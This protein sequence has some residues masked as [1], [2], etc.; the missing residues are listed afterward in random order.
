M[1]PRYVGLSLLKVLVF[2]HSELI[3]GAK[4]TV[5]EG[6]LGDLRVVPIPLND[7]FPFEPE[8]TSFIPVSF[9]AIVSDDARFHSWEENTGGCEV[10][11]EPA[12]KRTREWLDDGCDC[13]IDCC[14]YN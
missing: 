14:K 10:F 6:S 11:L 8:L 3:A 12:V 1:D 2:V 13:L 5:H 9:G 4:P 7:V